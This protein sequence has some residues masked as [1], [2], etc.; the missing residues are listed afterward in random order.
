MQ[1]DP[2]TMQKEGGAKAM[3]KLKKVKKLDPMIF[4]R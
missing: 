1:M 3:L 4:V 2:E